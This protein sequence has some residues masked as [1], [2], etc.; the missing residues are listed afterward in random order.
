MVTCKE[1]HIICDL[2]DVQGGGSM[3]RKTVEAVLLPLTD[4]IPTTPCVG[5][6]TKITQAIEIM[7]ERNVN[8]IMVVRDDKPVGVIHLEDAMK[9]L[10]LRFY[11]NL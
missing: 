1:D 7:I 3:K 5:T 8:K 11:S 2:T 9:E 6:A 10:G 4:N